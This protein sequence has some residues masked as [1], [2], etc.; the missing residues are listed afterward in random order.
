MWPAGRRRMVRTSPSSC[1]CWLHL[2]G[3]PAG[4]SGGRCGPRG[5]RP[6]ASRGWSRRLS[7]RHRWPTACSAPVS[8]SSGTSTRTSPPTPQEKGI[9][10]AL[11]VDFVRLACTDAYDVGILF[12]RDSDLIPAL[13]AVRD[14]EGGKTHVEVATWK[15]SSRLRFPDSQ[16]PWCHYL[17]AE[18]YEACRDDTDYTAP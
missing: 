2:A 8:R 15:G 1:S 7:W 18:D 4:G 3:R 14:L 12:S 9:D 17:S 6:V 11:A 16:L 5:A 13:E 10:V